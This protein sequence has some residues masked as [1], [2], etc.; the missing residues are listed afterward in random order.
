MSTPAPMST[1]PVDSAV[2]TDVRGATATAR[3]GS[4][5]GTLSTL[6]SDEGGPR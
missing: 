6:S 2:P 3:T 5:P 4:L 1:L